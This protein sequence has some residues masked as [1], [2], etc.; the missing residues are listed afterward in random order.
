MVEATKVFEEQTMFE[1]KKSYTDDGWEAWILE[2]TPVKEDEEQSAAPVMSFSDDIQTVLRLG[3][4]KYQNLVIELSSM[5][6]YGEEDD[7]IA[8][9]FIIGD[10]RIDAHGI[11]R[12]DDGI[13]IPTDRKGSAIKL[14]NPLPD[15]FYEW[16]EKLRDELQERDS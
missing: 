9:S 5:P 10:Q 11:Y 4:Y 12:G 13:A 16:L 14:S 3:R 15:D 7:S 2:M 8:L 6:I 1:I